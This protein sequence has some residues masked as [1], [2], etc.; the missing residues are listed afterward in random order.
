MAGQGA[1]YYHS[2][3]DRPAPGA[4]APPNAQQGLY[5][6]PP[7]HAQQPVPPPHS[8]PHFQTPMPEPQAFY[9]NY[10]GG[11]YPTAAAGGYPVGAPGGFPSGPSA[12][13][14]P[15]NGFGAIDSTTAALGQ[16]LFSNFVGGQG[17][18]LFSQSQDQVS[19]FARLPKY[20][21]QVNNKF[22]LRKIMLILFPLANRTWA[23]RRA[24]DAGEAGMNESGSCGYLPPS[25]DVNAPDLYI[26]VM[27][28]V[29][30]VLLVGFVKGSVGTF[31]PEDMASTG[32]KGLGLLL[33][34]VLLVRLGLYLVDSRA[35]AWFDIIGL[36]GYKFVGLIVT[37]LA[38]SLLP[39]STVYYAVLLY[40]ATMMGLFLMRT[41][42]RL[43]LPSAATQM[44]DETKKN[45]FLLLV[46]LIQYPIYWLLAER[47]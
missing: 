42:R 12:P 9:G 26:P 17:A 37:L 32:S 11:G 33:L 44:A 2:G 23:R 30:Y 18:R 27:S 24:S 19:R 39:T 36:Q 40:C 8:Q 4:T 13:P 1:F 31:K 20:Y 5:A 15:G 16:Q 45:Y 28:F 22:V 21:F 46:L 41:Y 29:T 10:A 6:Q 43:V 25:H 47:G 7:P 38:V 14:Q 34:E 3:S 35:I